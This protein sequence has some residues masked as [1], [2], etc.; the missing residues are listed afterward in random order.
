MGR[1]SINDSMTFPPF[2]H[3]SLLL[4]LFGWT[5][6]TSIL[7]V[8]FIHVPFQL[9]QDTCA[10]IKLSSNWQHACLTPFY[11][12]PGGLRREEHQI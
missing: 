5:C 3:L 4:S 7:V 10:S 1:Y 9:W 12:F 2:L 11:S 6:Y 8:R